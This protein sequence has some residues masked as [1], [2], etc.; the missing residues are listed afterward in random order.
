MPTPSERMRP[1][2]DADDDAAPSKLLRRQPATDT[3]DSVN[4]E[5]LCKSCVGVQKVWETDIWFPVTPYARTNGEHVLD[6]PDPH[7]NTNCKLCKFLTHAMSSSYECPFQGAHG[8]HLTGHSFGERLDVTSDGAIYDDTDILDYGED[9]G[10]MGVRPG[11]VQRNEERAQNRRDPET[12]I[13]PVGGDWMRMQNAW[14][15]DVRYVPPRLVAAANRKLEAKGS[16]ALEQKPRPGRVVCRT[17]VPGSANSSVL[18]RCVP[19]KLDQAAFDL[20]SGWIEH[21]KTDRAHWP[22]LN[23]SEAALPGFKLIDCT[24]RQ[25][26]EQPAST[27]YVTL[28]YVWGQDSATPTYSQSLPHKCPPLIEDVIKVVRELGYQYLWIDR[29]CINNQEEEEK[30]HQI[31]NMD[32]I[33]AQAELTIISTANGTQEALP[34][35]GKDREYQP[36]VRVGNNVYVANLDGGYDPIRGTPWAE[37]GWTFQEGL[38][39]RRRLIF[40][41]TQVIFECRTSNERESVRLPD[42]RPYKRQR[43]TNPK[44]FETLYMWWDPARHARPVAVDMLNDYLCRRLTYDSDILNAIMGVLKPLR[45]H[46]VYHIN[47]LLFTIDKWDSMSLRRGFL[48]SLR[49]GFTCSDPA[50]YNNVRCLRWKTGHHRN[51]ADYVFKWRESITNGYTKREGFPTWSWTGWSGLTSVY[52]DKSLLIWPTNRPEMRTPQ[53]LLPRVGFADTKKDIDWW[54][55]KLDVEFIADR[56]QTCRFL[57]LEGW[58][59]EARFDDIGCG[60][61]S[62]GDWKL[63]FSTTTP[64]VLK[65]DSVTAIMTC[66]ISPK[67]GTGAFTDTINL[68]Y[69]R[70]IRYLKDRRFSFQAGFILIQNY[71]DHWIRIGNACYCG[72][73]SHDGSPTESDGELILGELRLKKRTIRLG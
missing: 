45:R 48:A 4:E 25:I 61:E 68:D 58:C 23:R 2:S 1:I 60:E 11:T 7:E 39:S 46:S 64:G 30:H 36:S 10:I 32:T 56:H 73:L 14:C 3:E 70:D 18:G 43:I 6:I 13:V 63:H 47:G 66:T 29:Y 67:L 26:S 69:D 54:D 37:R 49:S 41:T 16:S 50:S 12:S 72:G 59:F 33:Y 24:T 62:L 31:A 20:I 51:R 38:L 35:V 55:D 22:C 19:P 17:S 5:G 9:T 8:C 44:L 53:D 71:G 28:S 57:H 21:C 34:G 27:P 40:D 42:C 65:G 52:M 15:W